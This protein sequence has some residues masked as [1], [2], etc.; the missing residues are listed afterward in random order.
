M[1]CSNLDPSEVRVYVKLHKVARDGSAPAQAGVSRVDGCEM[2]SEQEIEPPAEMVLIR[3]HRQ[4]AGLSVAEAAARTRGVVSHSRWVQ[5][6]RGTVIRKGEPARTSASDMALAHMAHAV[7]VTPDQLVGC[8]R[9]EAAEIL[10]TIQAPQGG[11]RPQ[12]E[13]MT[14][15]FSDTNIPITERRAR[16]EQILRLLPHLLSGQEPPAELLAQ[17]QSEEP[18]DDGGRER[19]NT[20]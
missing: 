8:G 2:A 5:L 3:R 19:R 7:G 17:L 4:A 1:D 10:E 12:L 6:E 18:Q 9:R 15:Y 16:A 13:A 11:R 14:R 20:A